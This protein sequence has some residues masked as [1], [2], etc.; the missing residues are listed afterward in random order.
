MTRSHAPTILT[1]LM[2]TSS[3][4]HLQWITLQW[5]V[6]YRIERFP[7]SISTWKLNILH[8]N[9]SNCRRSSSTAWISSTSRR[10]RRTGS[11]I[12]LPQ[13][14]PSQSSL[15]HSQHKSSNLQHN[16]EIVF[17]NIN[18]MLDT[19]PSG[20][21]PVWKDIVDQVPFPWGNH[22]RGLSPRPLSVHFHFPIQSGHCDHA[23]R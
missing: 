12:L 9:F 13:R 20:I 2:R 7:E 19:H 22:E 3:Q 6:F 14:L 11:I 4:R 1:V 17:E 5:G 15:I 23:V 18:H 10:S 21:T 8:Y 16:V